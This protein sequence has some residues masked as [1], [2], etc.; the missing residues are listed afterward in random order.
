VN[1]CARIGRAG[2]FQNV[3][4][5]QFSSDAVT[6]AE[7]G[8]RTQSV[9]GRQER[10]QTIAQL[11]KVKTDLQVKSFRQLMSLSRKTL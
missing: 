2:L 6:S 4:L 11:P 7:Y 9:Q 3:P 8:Q 10:F 1:S 5:R